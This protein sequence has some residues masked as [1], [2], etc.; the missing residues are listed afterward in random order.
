MMHI[1]HDLLTEILVLQVTYIQ[2]FNFQLWVDFLIFALSFSSMFN[3]PSDKLVGCN[4][5]PTYM[6]MGCSVHSL[7]IC[8]PA[9][10]YTPYLYGLQC[11][12]P[13]YMWMDCSV[14]SPAAHGSPSCLLYWLYPQINNG[15][16]LMGCSVHSLPVCWWT[17]VYPSWQPVALHPGRCID[18]ITK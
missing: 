9:A 7:P 17:A 11:T 4:P 12:L 14:L 13:T 18:C 15:Y 6:L 16:M 10:V 3:H 5:L 2:G 1:K 8:C